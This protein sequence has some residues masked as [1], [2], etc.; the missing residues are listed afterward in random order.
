M[1]ICDSSTRDVGGN[2]PHVLTKEAVATGAFQQLAKVGV[3]ALE[4]IHEE[5]RS[6]AEQRVGRSHDFLDAAIDNPAGDFKPLRAAEARSTVDGDFTLG[7]RP[8]RS[9]NA[10]V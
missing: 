7:I 3:E 9:V 5:V 1:V 2:L 10:S 8:S 6:G 4:A